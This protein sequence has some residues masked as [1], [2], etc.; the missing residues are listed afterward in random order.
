MH[1][2]TTNILNKWLKQANYNISLKELKMQFLSHPDV[3]NLSSITDT[4]NHFNIDNQAVQIEADSL[5]QFTE[6]F[7]AFIK[8]DHIEQFVLVTPNASN[9]VDINNGKDNSFALS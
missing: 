6:P 1:E 9:N 2:T 4:L 3:G 5:L 7:I 8:S